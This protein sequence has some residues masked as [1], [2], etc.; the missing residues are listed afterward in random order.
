MKNDEIGNTMIAATPRA[1]INPPNCGIT[2][3]KI[4]ATISVIIARINAKIACTEE[5]NIVNGASSTDFISTMFFHLLFLDG[6]YYIITT[7]LT[8]LEK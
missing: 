4:P 8:F 1:M 3:P 5:V 7:I 6:Y 2:A